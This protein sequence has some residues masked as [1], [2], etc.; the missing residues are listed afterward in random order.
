MICLI[1]KG[2]ISN[3]AAKTVLEEIIDKDVDPADVVKEKGLAQI[4]D[5]SALVAVVQEVLAN[6]PK[7]V[8]DFKNGKTN[9]LG[10][11]LGQC[12]R[13]SKGQGNPNTLREIIAEEIAKL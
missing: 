7:A 10:F 5:S 9:V 2:T 6:N 3:T 8:A 12:M 13:A 4:S 11:V 1:Q